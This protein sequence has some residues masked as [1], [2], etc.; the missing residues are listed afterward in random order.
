MPTSWDFYCF[1]K[2]NLTKPDKS[3]SKKHGRGIYRRFF[4]YVPASGEGA[5]NY[6][7]TRWTGVKGSNGVHQ[8]ASG[9]NSG[10]VQIR[11]RS[12]HCPPC[13]DDD[14]EHCL[15]FDSM[16]QELMWEQPLDMEVEAA[17]RRP[18][19]RGDQEKKGHQIAMRGAGEGPHLSS[20]KR[21]GCGHD[22]PE[23]SSHCS[24]RLWSRSTRR[25]NHH[26]ITRCSHAAIDLRCDDLNRLN[27]EFYT[28]WGID[29]HFVGWCQSS[30]A[31]GGGNFTRRVLMGKNQPTLTKEWKKA[32]QRVHQATRIDG[33]CNHRHH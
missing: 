7:I 3:L 11:G 5:I 12:C 28:F 18:E 9:V 30:P 15:W 31:Q 20:H 6:N 1:C 10:T 32:F 19:L 21:S 16:K 29:I 26:P 25:I 22:R 8:M 14:S 23:S 27:A 24:I 2:E 13:Y 17:G 33:L 4:Y